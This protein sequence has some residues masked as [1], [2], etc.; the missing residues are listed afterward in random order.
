[1]DVCEEHFDI[2]ID[3]NEIID[4]AKVIIKKIRPSWPLQQLHFKVI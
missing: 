3:E 4:G 2:S 1:M